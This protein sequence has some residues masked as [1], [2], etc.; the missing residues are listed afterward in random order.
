LWGI[1]NHANTESTA[2]RLSNFAAMQKPTMA[3]LFAGG[4]TDLNSYQQT[5]KKP[6]HQGNCKNSGERNEHRN[7]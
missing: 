4:T 2:Y 7:D 3:T 6:S 1:F 5:N